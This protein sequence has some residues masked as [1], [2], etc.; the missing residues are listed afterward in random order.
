MITKNRFAF[1]IGLT[2]SLII[3]V[4]GLSFAQPQTCEN[5]WAGKQI[6][7]WV[8]K[9]L[10]KGYPDGTFKP[11]NSITRA[12]FMSLV[13]RSFGFVADVHI[14]FSDVSPTDWFAGEV[15]KAASVGYIAGYKDG[16]VRPNKMISR[17]EAAVMV[18]RI[19]K[20]DLSTASSQASN[21]KDANEIPSWSKGA[22][23]TLAAK[24]IM[25]GYPD[26]SFQPGTLISRA[27]AVVILDRSIAAQVKTVNYDKA[28]TYGP[29]SGTET[30]EGNVFISAAGVILQNVKITGNLFLAESIGTGNVTLKNVTVV[31]ET[32][33]KGG[34]A[35]SIVFEN[36]TLPGITVNKEGVR[37]VASG[38]T[39]I[40]IARLESGAVLVE[41]TTTGPGFETVTVSEAV[42]QG[43]KIILNGN[44]NNVVIDGDDVN[45]EVTG[46]TVEKLEVTDKST[47]SKIN[48]SNSAKITTLVLNAAVNVTGTGSIDTAIINV[49]GS[50]I[51]PVP[52]HVEKADNITVT[53]GT[54]AGGGTGS[55]TGTGGGNA[56]LNLVGA[57]LEAT[58]VSI[59]GSNSVPINPT[60]KLVFDRGVVR[61]HW[62][63]NQNCFT[64]RNQSGANIP[65]NVSRAANYTDDSEKRNIYITPVNNL[66]PGITYTITISANL[67]ANND[68]TLGVQREIVFT[69]AAGGGGGG[70]GND[71]TPPVLAPGYPA[72]TRVLQT[73]VDLLIKTNE[74][75]KV[76]Y[77]VLDNAAPAPTAAQVKA[78]HDAN[79][80]NAAIS[81]NG[82]LTA[83]TLAT[84]NVVGLI[85]GTVYDL[86]VVAEDNAQNLQ[87]TPVKISVTTITETDLST[88]IVALPGKQTAG[89]PFDFSI[90]EAKD[91]AGT[92]LGGSTAVTVYSDKD[93]GVFSGNV[94]FTA[95]AAT[96]SIAVYTAGTNT[97]TVTIAGVTPRPQVEVTTVAA[98][99]I[100]SKNSSTEI[101]PV[102]AKG[103][104]SIITIT[105]K[106]KYNNPMANVTKNIK[107]VVTVTNDS[108]TTTEEY[109]V[110]GSLV[111]VT[112][113]LSRE[114]VTTDVYGKVAFY[115]TL[116][117]TI[118]AGDGVSI[119]V[120]QNNGTPIGNA[121]TYIEP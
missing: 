66:I 55:G 7:D 71:S 111:T 89:V 77:V 70:G 41:T 91:T 17:Q 110:D 108:P 116:P 3:A 101:I 63:N 30:L 13:N 87:A 62:D 96:V 8:T 19:L 35:N 38:N 48:L 65:I 46:G 27:E 58:G 14:E 20:L 61:D 83:N 2:L 88:A 12:E 16:T 26:G 100:S 93:G 24:G 45:L 106:D 81:G 85:A 54:P 114:S 22:V 33:I 95:G 31:G 36:C 11:D 86:Y 118:D 79:N 21:F 25:N 53:I 112:E 15:A 78:G 5:H 80:Q 90:T 98:T 76:Y 34:G 115:V 6:G 103:T 121:F 28:G 39:F 97:L 73:S 57:Y 117:A 56:P 94:I 9:G 47:G 102:L 104:T 60:I 50:T 37:I 18:T 69:V 72:I 29:Q 109:M 51:K 67:Q 107:I 82:N 75:G 23:C 113:T 59:E 92:D 119:Q 1:I 84:I 32:I 10:I 42:P 43:S 120:T 64:M 99:Q 105:L 52:L 44:F 49:S 40:K 4:G 74:N 68:N